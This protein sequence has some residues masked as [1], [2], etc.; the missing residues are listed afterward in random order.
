MHNTD[1]VGI[2][3]FKLDQLVLDINS[4]ALKIKNKL[5][6]I[7]DLVEGSKVYF[8]C[9]SG[10]MYRDKFK[11]VKGTFPI[12]NKNIINISND[13]VSAK[14]RINNAESAVKTAFIEASQ[15]IKLSNSLN[16]NED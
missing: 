7:S 12:V 15:D 2:N 3:E 6:E 10:N 13:L 9:E 14:A 1:T 5:D 16:K 11:N 4:S 8:D